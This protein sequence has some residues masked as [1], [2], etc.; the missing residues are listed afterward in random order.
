LID[1]KNENSEYACEQVSEKLIEDYDI[2]QVLRYNNDQ[3]L[4]LCSNSALEVK[5]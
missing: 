3:Y 1:I 2:K 4:M 5:R